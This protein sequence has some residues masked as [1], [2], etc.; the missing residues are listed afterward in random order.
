VSV[1]ID[2]MSIDI[3]IKRID[4][5]SM[6][7]DIDAMSMRFGL[8]RIRPAWAARRPRPGSA[9][10]FSLLL[11]EYLPARVVSGKGRKACYSSRKMASN[12]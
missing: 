4:T 11:H 1:A 5:G 10:R 7:V 12:R 6:S 9:P 2:A 3:V 8:M